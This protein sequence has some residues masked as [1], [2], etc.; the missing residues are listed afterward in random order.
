MAVKRE[1]GECHNYMKKFSREHLKV[2]PMKGIYLLQMDDT[3]AEP[4]EDLLI[5]LN[6]ITG[7]ASA[8]TL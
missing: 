8:D 6:A 3:S 1:R 5:S 4:G 7:L 2:C